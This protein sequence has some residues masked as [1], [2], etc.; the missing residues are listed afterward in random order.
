MEINNGDEITICDSNIKNVFILYKQDGGFYFSSGNQYLSTRTNQ[1]MIENIATISSQK[2]VFSLLNADKSV[3]LKISDKYEYIIANNKG[4]LLFEDEN[5]I[6]NNK[7]KICLHKKNNVIPPIKTKEIV[8]PN[9]ETATPNIQNNPN[10]GRQNNSNLGNQTVDLVKI[11]QVN[12]SNN[13]SLLIIL[14]I[15]LFGIILVLVVVIIIIIL[16]MPSKKE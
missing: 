10:L 14:L 8:T 1:E 6:F 11:N 9:I 7:V 15:I 12:V 13:N 2:E 5:N 4:S 16:V 3:P